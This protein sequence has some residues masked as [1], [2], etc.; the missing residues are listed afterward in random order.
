MSLEGA[1]DRPWG[2]AAGLGL[3]LDNF[4][5]CRWLGLTGDRRQVCHWSDRKSTRSNIG[6]S[7][8]FLLNLLGLDAVKQLRLGMEVGKTRILVWTQL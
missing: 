4:R 7:T 8:T 6:L 5:G 1:W 3:R 2:G